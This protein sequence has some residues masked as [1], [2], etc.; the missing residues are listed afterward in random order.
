MDN[1]KYEEWKDIPNFEGLY[2]VSNLGRVKS[3]ER[4]RKGANGSLVLVKEKILK[5]VISHNGYYIV[6]LH[7]Q[8]I[9]KSYYIHR[10]VFEA[11]NGQIPEGYEINHL[12]ERPVNNAL[13]NLSLV[14]HKENLNYGTRNERAGK[15]LKNGKC[16]KSVLQFTLDNILV[17]EYPS[18]KQVER[19]TGFANQ[20]ICACCK[21]KLKTAYGYKWKYAK[22]V[23]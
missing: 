14:T 6:S 10:L 20:S 18:I 21:G 8:S 3:L 9:Q 1:F 13:S 16:S 12:D 23:D 22:E 5:L 17:K 7:K 15:V 2:Q 19:E 4:F 11:F